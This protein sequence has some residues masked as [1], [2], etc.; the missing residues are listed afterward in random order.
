LGQRPIDVIVGE[1][2]A[3]LRTSRGVSQDQL[4][5]VLGTTGQQIADYEAGKTRI[6][7]AHLIEVCKFFQV[8]LQSLFPSSDSDYDTNLH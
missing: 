6:P 3:G 7:P 8:T 2:I 5:L 4:R 1:R